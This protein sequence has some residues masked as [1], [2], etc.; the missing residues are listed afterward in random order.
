MNR[1]LIMALIVASASTSFANNI[2]PIIKGGATVLVPPSRFQAPDGT[3]ITVTY[4]SHGSLASATGTDASGVL[5]EVTFSA[6]AEE[7]DYYINLVDGQNP[8]LSPTQK[9]FCYVTP[10]NITCPMYTTTGQ[11]HYYERGQPVLDYALTV[12]PLNQK[13]TLLASKNT[14]PARTLREKVQIKRLQYTLSYVGDKGQE[15]ITYNTY[16]SSSTS[17]PIDVSGGVGNIRIGIVPKFAAIPEIGRLETYFRPVLN[18]AFVNS[19]LAPGQ[20]LQ[21]YDA[22]GVPVNWG[23]GRYFG[24]GVIALATLGS[25]ALSGGAGC[26]LSGITS[27]VAADFWTSNVPAS[28]GDPNH[29]LDDLVAAWIHGLCGG[30]DDLWAG[31][32]GNAGA[33]IGC[34]SGY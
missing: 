28:N 17:F 6:S 8:T 10:G 20:N 32:V 5:R 1:P 13:I 12:D 2:S 23:T 11:V 33:P 3:T 22:N 30:W 34:P 16:A 24:D 27:A 26:A 25:C 31:L 15:D 7:H 21:L 14:L 29:P 4:D 19:S 18:Y 9:A